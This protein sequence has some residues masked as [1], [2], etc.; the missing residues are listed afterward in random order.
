MYLFGRCVWR[1]CYLAEDYNSFKRELI[2]YTNKLHLLLLLVVVV[3][4]V[5]TPSFVPI[6]AFLHIFTHLFAILCNARQRVLHTGDVEMEW[7]FVSCFFGGGLPG[8]IFDSADRGNRFVRNVGELPTTSH[9]I[10][11]L[12][13]SARD[14]Q[15]QGFSHRDGEE[16]PSIFWIQHDCIPPH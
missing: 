11:F 4:S 1:W 8:L 6:I 2:L 12:I 14:P 15:I 13:G 16:F 5:P 7:A 9:A 10:V 3:E